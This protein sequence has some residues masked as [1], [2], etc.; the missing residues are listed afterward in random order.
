M[1]R[2]DRRARYLGVLREL[3][4]TTGFTRVTT[5][6]MAAALHCS[7]AVIYSLWRTKEA[8]VGA[9]IQDFLREVDDR[10]SRSASQMDDAAERISAYLTAVGAQMR[11]MSTTCYRDMM[12]NDSTREIY[13]AEARARSGRL[14]GYLR[15]GVAAGGFR[16]TH[17]EFV[18]AAVTLLAGEPSGCLA[19]RR[20]E[21]APVE[22]YREMSEL[23]VVSLTN[24]AW[25]DDLLRFPD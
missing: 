24:H 12:S 19:G 15:E 13:L 4:L 3:I 20:D 5:A 9:A 21:P 25:M 22:W 14:A 10:A 8:I 23:V 2:D 1:T 6:R 11:R 16:P 7:K 17:I 18:T